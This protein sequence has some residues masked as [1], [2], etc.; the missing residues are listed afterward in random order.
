MSIL[1][2]YH[3]EMPEFINELATTKE[4]QRLRGVGMNCGCEYTDFSN[5]T[6]SK[7]YF[8]WEHSVGVALIIWHFTK[9]IKQTIAGLLHDICTPAF[10]HVVDFLHKDYEKQESTEAKTHEFIANSKQIQAILKKYN[11][12][13]VDVDDYHRY[14][15]A[16]N[17]APKLSA[18]RLEYTMGNF[19]SRG[20]MNK[21]EIMAIYN[22]I[23]IT[24][25]ELGEVELG[26]TNKEIAEKFTNASL[27]NSRYYVADEDRF[28]MQYL[29]DLLQKGLDR[30]VISNTDL[31]Q[32]EHRVIAL[33]QSHPDTN[34]L[35]QQFIS[36]KE[37]LIFNQ[38]Q[39]FY[40]VKIPAKKRY[41][42]PLVNEKRVMDISPVLKT[43]ITVFLEKNF[44]YWMSEKSLMANK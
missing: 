29:A 17:D 34:K 22:D 40:T 15:I 37:I 9:D 35:W 30:G 25:N 39:N 36:F 32:D 1:D 24:K 33:L 18:D 43:E 3:Y 12:T 13:T 6:S 31:Y 14:P 23:I 38:K 5:Y 41:I 26:F 19:Y 2:I 21:E 27:D 28:S 44:D 11:L 7:E 8:R 16:D 4:M 42:N 20:L 10:S